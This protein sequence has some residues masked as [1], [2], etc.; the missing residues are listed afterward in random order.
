MAGFDVVIEGDPAPVRQAAIDALGYRSFRF[1]W[2]DEWSAL[3]ERGSKV[4]NLLGG[5]I[6]QYFAIE[7]RIMAGQPGHTVVRFEQQ[8]SG[9]MG[10]AIG[11]ARVKKNLT[12]LRDEFA[13]FFAQ[14]NRLVGVDE[15]A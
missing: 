13:G 12:T 3:A 11:A 6:A 10:G 1:T 8:N 4:G 9:W 2:H 5:A 7:V 14:Q 15:H